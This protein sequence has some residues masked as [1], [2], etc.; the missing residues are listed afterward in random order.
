MNHMNRKVFKGH[1]L[2]YFMKKTIKPKTKE[3]ARIVWYLECPKCKKEITGNYEEQAIR[4]LESHLK[5]HKRVSAI[6][7]QKEIKKESKKTQ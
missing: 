7:K 3:I 6:K 1:M 5:R 2:I 4:N